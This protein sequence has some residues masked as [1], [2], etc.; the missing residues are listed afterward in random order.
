MKK[1]LLI[2]GGGSEQLIAVRIAK[3]LGYKTLVV[4]DNKHAV[5]GLEA[6]TF[7]SYKIKD[8]YG[9]MKTLEY[10]NFDGVITHASELAIEVA[11]IARHFNL[12]GIS[13]DSAE[14]ATLK[15]K[16]LAC[17]KEFG[18]KIPKFQ[19]VGQDLKHNLEYPII[20]KPT[21]GKGAVGVQ[22][23]KN[24]LELKEY[25]KPQIESECYIVEE[26]LQG[27]QY[28]TESIIYN[29]KILRTNIAL[30]HY[31]DRFLPYMIEDGHSMPVT[32]DF[33]NVILD[34][35]K[36]LDI[37]SG[38][39]KGDLLINENGIYVIEMAARTSGGRFADFV[40]PLQCGIN[41]LY[42]LIQMSMGEKIDMKYLEE[43]W[44]YGVSQRFFFS[45]VNLYKL[46]TYRSMSGVE[47][48]VISED[49]R[50][51]RKPKKIESHRD[52]TGYVICK[53]RTREEADDLA[54]KII[55]ELEL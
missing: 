33:D 36:S 25:N 16:R 37:T 30:R 51:T 15:H 41:I 28:S 23:I 50:K 11:M 55:K 20:I 9:L 12:N 14:K 34:T 48:I 52:R 19:I 10:Y 29:G 26:Y 18:I 24:E 47:D 6:D 38:V 8:I 49:Y 4:D 22:L 35:C 7:I 43:Q 42:P 27:I 54:L 40:T 31:D 45:D 5:C 17:F 46:D 3:V 44:N 2:L 39:V 13:V 32:L 21:N 53:A 1:T